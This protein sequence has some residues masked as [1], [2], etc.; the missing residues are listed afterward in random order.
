MRTLYNIL[1]SIFFVLASPYY[2]MRM[3]RRGNWRTGFAERFGIFPENFKQSITNRHVIWFHAVSVGEVNICTQVIRAV[4]P[5]VPNAKIIVSTTT[6]TGMQRLRARLPTHIGKI[7]YPV[8]QRKCVSRALAAVYPQ[9]IVLVEAE[10]WP[11][12]IWRALDMRIPIFLVNAR[13]S[14]RSYRG[15]KRFAFLFRPLF[16]SFTG[17]GAQNETDAAR[18]R[19]LG[20][21][22]EAIHIVGNLK[23]D[24]AAHVET[25]RTLNVGDILRR[26][27]VMS[28]ARILLGGSTH[29]G[30]ELI[31]AEI[32]Q[33]LRKQFPDLFLILAPRHFERSRDAAR[34]VRERGVKLIF[35]TEVTTDAQLQPGEVDCLLV[36]TTNELNF[37]YEHATIVFI[38]KSLTAEGGQNPIEPAA[39][40]KAVIFGPNMQ[41]FSDVAR[42]FLAQDAAVQVQD[43]AELEQ[44]VAELLANEPRRVQLG[45]NALKVVT[46]NLGAVNR[47]VDMILK[48]L[49]SGEI[50]IKK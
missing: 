41:N 43:A 37:F 34:D 32:F 14:E 18:L 2:F 30:E 25:R 44:K 17:V 40:N 13:L 16:A 9:A 5:A 12:F 11:N 29:D 28:G 4:E 49:S 39:L 19:E 7:Y 6:T 1:F 47:T 8:D 45:R 35:R 10:I 20:C 33:H 46:E 3:W 50:Y 31:L 48:H 38:G 26:V 23:F 36:N 27:G 15:Y 24:A 21:R 22:P 42:S